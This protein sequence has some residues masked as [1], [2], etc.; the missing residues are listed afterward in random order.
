MAVLLPFFKRHN[1]AAHHL[2]RLIATLVPAGLFR[3]SHGGT[4]RRRRRLLLSNGCSV[5]HWALVTALTPF[6]RCR[7]SDQRSSTPQPSGV[8]LVM[9]P[10]VVPIAGLILVVAQI[11]YGDTT[12][13]QG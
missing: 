8:S 4:G 5:D 1:I 13:S 10:L 7:E 11:I 2:C 3:R 12:Q 6:W 9:D